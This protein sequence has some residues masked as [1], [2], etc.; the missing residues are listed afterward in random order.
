MT[1]TAPLTAKALL[2]AVPGFA[3]L[4]FLAPAANAAVAFTDPSFENGG[5]ATMVDDTN[6]NTAGNANNALNTVATGIW[7]T[8]VINNGQEGHLLEDKDSYKGFTSAPAGV[9][10]EQFITGSRGPNNTRGLLQYIN[11]GGSTTGTLTLSIDY[12]VHELNASD[13]PAGG[14]NFSFEIIAFND[15]ATVLMDLGAGVDN[16][17]ISGTG[18]ITSGG[19]YSSYTAVSAATGFQT[20]QASLDL[21]AGYDYVGVAIGI[22]AF[23]PYGNANGET[24]S[25]DNL[26]VVPEPSAFALLGL[27][28]LALLLRRRR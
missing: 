22:S 10:G 12:W 11:D 14:G 21:G 20:L 16:P 19:S 6:Y 18:Y 7:H 3:A 9:T 17:I 25:F 1:I 4:A 26:Q 5:S 13:S 27:S 23:D 2:F 24:V 28:G 8:N 15:P